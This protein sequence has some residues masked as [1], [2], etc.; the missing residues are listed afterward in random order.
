MLII[1]IIKITLIQ[2][3]QSFRATPTKLRDFSLLISGLPLSVD[4]SP[5]QTSIRSATF[6]LVAR[7]ADRL[8]NGGIVDRNSPHRIHEIRPKKGTFLY[9]AQR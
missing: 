2:L 3:K 5:P 8:T 9:G 6:A 1:A 7:V 4:P